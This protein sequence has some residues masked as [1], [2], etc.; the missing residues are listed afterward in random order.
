MKNMET[1]K[2]DI[3]FYTPIYNWGLALGE[4]RNR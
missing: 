2:C 4:Q 1:E 3:S